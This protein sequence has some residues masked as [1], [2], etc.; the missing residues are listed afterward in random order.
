MKEIKITA[1]NIDRQEV[2]QLYETAFPE[3][4][5]IPYNDLKRLLTVMSLDFTAW[6][7]GNIFVGLTIVYERKSG[8]WFWYFA[9]REELRGQGYGT[10]IL[11]SLSKRYESQSLILDIESPRQPSENMEQRK[12]RYNFYLRNGFRDTYVGRTFKGITYTIL[13]SG[14]FSFTS[15]DYDDILKELRNCWDA[16]PTEEK[17]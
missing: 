11:E 8:C 14:S 3:V 15:Q 12:R 17:S 10:K 7:D 5:R 9:V 13:A 2:R 1:E 6:Y 4:E 16:M